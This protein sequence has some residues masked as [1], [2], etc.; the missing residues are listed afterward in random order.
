[1][2]EAS[3][4]GIKP[5]RRLP[6]YSDTNCTAASLAIT[7]GPGLSTANTLT[8]ID[9]IKIIASESIPSMIRLLITE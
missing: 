4:T 5:D 2:K 3:Y 6:L 7:Y 8:D 1:M 9:S